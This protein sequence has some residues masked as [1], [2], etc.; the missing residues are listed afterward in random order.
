V[1]AENPVRDLAALVVLEER[2]VPEGLKD[3][4]SARREGRAYVV[5]VFFLIYEYHL[6]RRSKRGRMLVWIMFM[7]TRRNL[8]LHAETLVPSLIC[9]SVQMYVQDCT[10]AEIRRFHHNGTRNIVTLL[11]SLLASMVECIGFSPA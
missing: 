4:G 5:L 9:T 10:L 8:G 3:A 1:L 7:N 2:E 11:S 6:S